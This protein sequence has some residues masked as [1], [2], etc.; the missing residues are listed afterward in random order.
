MS[1]LITNAKIQIQVWLHYLHS[2]GF[3]IQ[4]K[5]AKMSIVKLKLVDRLKK[6][7]LNFNMDIE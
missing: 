7:R 4:K 3:H 1:V 2:N 5:S 6:I